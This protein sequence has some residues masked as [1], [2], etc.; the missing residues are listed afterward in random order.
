MF[1]SGQC[2][3]LFRKKNGILPWSSPG[4]AAGDDVGSQKEEQRPSPLGLVLP[5]WR[6]SNIESKQENSVVE[7]VQTVD[8]KI[9]SGKS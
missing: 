1:S 3:S 5:P 2:L 6:P 9:V 7:H 8:R 4:S